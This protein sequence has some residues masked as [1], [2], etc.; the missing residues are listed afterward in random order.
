MSYH[1]SY[2]LIF[3]AIVLTVLV[4]IVIKWQVIGAGD[5]ARLTHSYFNRDPGYEGVAF[6]VDSAYLTDSTFCGLLVIAFQDTH[7]F[8]TT[9]G[10]DICCVTIMA[11][12]K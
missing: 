3:P 7:S 1:M 8:S 12:E 9:R 4:Q 2:L 10:L 5:I 6:T 11:T